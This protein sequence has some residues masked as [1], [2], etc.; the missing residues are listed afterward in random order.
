MAF[1]GIY[2][3]YRKG[4]VFTEIL[5]KEGI[6]LLKLLL[7]GTKRKIVCY[8]HLPSSKS[9]IYKIAQHLKLS[10]TNN[11]KAAKEK[12]IVIYYEYATDMVDFDH[13]PTRKVINSALRTI[14]KDAVNDFF[15]QAFGYTSLVDPLT[16]EGKCVEKGIINA[17]HSGEIVECPLTTVKKDHIY[18]V[19][20]DNT[21]EN[22]S[23]QD[24]RVPI[25][26]KVID[27]VLLKHRAVEER[28]ET[29]ST[30][31]IIKKTEE[32]LTK[33]EIQNINKFVQLMHLEYGE[34]DVL[35]DKT[36]NKIYIV[37]VNNTPHYPRGSQ[38]DK[39]VT[40]TI[41]V[42]SKNLKENF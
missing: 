9:Q 41:G 17:T 1:R 12:D 26:G 10:L 38:S 29:S 27:I 7:N 33:E 40:E 3:R 11:L 24:I 21:L 22:G 35:R 36:T 30:Q 19:L 25:F 4:T 23:V 14:S 42:Y 2:N 15:Q 32:I 34:L 16:F 5:F 6:F 37:D 39:E 20:I 18:Q 8:P 31:T 28:F 13:L